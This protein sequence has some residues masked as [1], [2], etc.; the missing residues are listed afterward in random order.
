M[1]RNIALLGSTGSI[2]E[3][4]LKVARHL[5]DRIRVKA[6]AARGNIDLL[7]KQAREFRPALVAVAEEKQAAELKKR[8][9][10]MEVAVGVEG[11]KAVAAHADIDLAVCAISGTAGLVPTMAAIEAGKDIALANKES[12]VSGGALVMDAVKRQGVRLLPIDS[13]HSAIFQCLNGENKAAVARLILTS[14]GGPFRSFTAEQLR[15]A[16]V[17]QALRHPTWSMGAKVTIDSS[18]LMNKGL[19]VVEAH[20][21]FD[22]P[23]DKIDVIIHPQSI[24]HSMVEFADGAMMAQM[25]APTMIVPIQ[26]ALTYPD[27]PPGL[28]QPF[29]FLKNH[30]LQFFAPDRDKFRCLHLAYEAIRQGKSLPCY[31]NAANEVLVGRCLEKQIAWH[32]IAAKLEELM[33]RHAVQEIASLE[34]VLAMDR[35]A[36]REALAF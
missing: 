32:E 34:D 35:L 22:M 24:I 11:M 21:L 19:E 16:K 23:L 1:T 14:S 8:L 9:P 36:R 15:A 4:T 29:D 10:G 5:P 2:G 6:L 31:M 13:E 25:S 3:N 12:L 17:E 27:R 18:T 28:I 20:W 30:T 7:E 26:Y 33:T